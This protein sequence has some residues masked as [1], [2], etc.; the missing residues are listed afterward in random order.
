MGAGRDIVVL[1][2]GEATDFV[3]L[4]DASNVVVKVP[5]AANDKFL[6]AIDNRNCSYR[7]IMKQPSI[8]QNVAVCLYEVTLEQSVR[9][10]GGE[11]D[12]PPKVISIL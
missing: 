4:T 3:A 12:D 9:C 7:F 2:P 10:V 6:S 11:G 1:E 8:E 5:G